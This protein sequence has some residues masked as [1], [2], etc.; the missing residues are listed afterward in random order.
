MAV[1]LSDSNASSAIKLGGVE[2]ADGT[3]ALSP[4]RNVITV[5]I[6]A[7][8]GVTTRIYTVA[9]T[10][11][12]TP[13]ALSSDGNAQIALSERHRLRHVRLGHNDVQFGCDQRRVADDGNPGR[14]D[15]EATHVIKVGRRLDT[16]GEVSLAVG[17]NVITVEV[18]AEDGETTQT[19]TVTVTRAEASTPDPAPTETCVQSVADDATIENSW[20]ESCRSVKVAPGGA[21]DRYA[22]FYTF[23]LDEAAIITITLESD[24]DTYLYVLKGH[25]KDGETLHYNDDIASGGVNLNSRV[26]VT[27]QPGDYTIEATTLFTRNFR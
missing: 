26:E 20:D 2:D 8:D 12:K 11:A 19:Y 21:G 17:D 22:R 4:G 6:T 25:G 9:V 15:V 18:T 3:I 5:H 13:D 14:N 27:L 1:T 24:E 16:D 7:E 10:R 23:T